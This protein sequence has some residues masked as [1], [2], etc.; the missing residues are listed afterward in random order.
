[1]GE[2]KDKS[3]SKDFS[4]MLKKGV[5]AFILYNILHYGLLC[6]FP[7]VFRYYLRYWRSFDPVMPADAPKDITPV[8]EVFGVHNYDELKKYIGDDVIIFRNYTDCASTFNNIVYPRR[9]DQLDNYVKIS[10]NPEGPGNLY[11][12]GVTKGEIVT[13]SLKEVF[14]RTDPHK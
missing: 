14:K 1:M 3:D 2:I 12:P 5:K 7:S 10:Y 11:T 6:A 4:A 8:K 13:R 9:K